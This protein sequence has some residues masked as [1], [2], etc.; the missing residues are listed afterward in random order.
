MAGCDLTF[1]PDSAKLADP[2]PYFVV[3]AL[4]FDADGFSWLNFE[5][6]HDDFQAAFD[7][8]DD[9]CMS[10]G[11]AGQQYRIVRRWRQP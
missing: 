5:D 3:Q 6:Q 7:Q 8:L 9:L 11:P 2:V 10:S 4:A 1:E